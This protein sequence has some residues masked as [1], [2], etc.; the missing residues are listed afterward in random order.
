MEYLNSLLSYLS[1]SSCST[2]E[3]IKLIE[4]MK[5]RT[6]VVGCLMC[7][8]EILPPSEYYN[9]SVC[10]DG[11][12]NICPSCIQY[13]KEDTCH[14]YYKEI[15]PY[16]LNNFKAIS[17][18]TYST[19]LLNII[20]LYEERRC[21]GYRLF[22]GQVLEDYK[23][24]SYKQVGMY[25]NSIVKFLKEHSIEINSEIIICADCCPESYIIL[26][27]SLIANMICIPL[28][29]TVSKEQ[30][31][32][33]LLKCHSPL[34]FISKHLQHVF[35][36]CLS[37]FKFVFTVD[38]CYEA[39]DVNS[40]EP[41]TKTYPPLSSILF[42]DEKEETLDIDQTNIND[43]TPRLLLS[44]SGSTG[45]PKLV[46]ETE[47]MLKSQLVETK[48][49]IE[50]IT[51]SFTLI[52]QL[53]NILSKGGAIACYSGSLERLRKDILLVRPT[54]FGATPSF[55]N[56]LYSEFKIEKGS[57]SDPLSLETFKKKKVLGNRCKQV[58]ITGAKSSDYIK[59]FLFKIGLVVTDGYGTS[60]TGSLINM[61]TGKVNEGVELK[62]IDCEEMGFYVT[63]TP[64]R[65]EVVAKTQTMTT[66]YFGDDEL[67]E[68]MFTQ[69]DGV[70]YFKT[71]DVGMIED[72][73]VKIID[74]KAFCFKTQQGVFVTPTV[75][76]NALIGVLGIEQIFVFGGIEINGVMGVVYPT[77]NSPLQYNDI[78]KNIKER[79]KEKQMK[80]YETVSKV[81]IAK[82][83]FGVE[84]GLL[85]SN[86]KLNR[87]K[88]LERYKKYSFCLGFVIVEAEEETAILQQSEKGEEPAQNEKCERGA[89]SQKMENILRN[90]VKG[91]EK[92]K[93]IESV[94]EYK[95]TDFG[96]DSICMALISKS[97]QDAFGVSISVLL[98]YKMR[99]IKEIENYINTGTFLEIEENWE[100]EITKHVIPYKAIPEVNLT[101]KRT[102]LLLGA[103]G[104][105]GKFIL[106]SLCDIKERVICV[107]RGQ[108]VKRR[109]LDIFN[110]ITQFEPKEKREEITQWFEEQVTVLSGD[111][112]Q[113]NFGISKL[114]C[115][116]LQT[117]KVII[118]SCGR[119]H[120]LE[121]YDNLYPQNVIPMTTCV[122]LA[123]QN[124]AFLI[125][126]S[127]LSCLSGSGIN[128]EVKDVP[129]TSIDR[130]NGYAQSKLIA[131]KIML[132][133]EGYSKCIIRLG[134]AGF[135]RASGVANLQSKYIR[136]I[137]SILSSN[138][139]CYE[140]KS[141][142]PLEIP[143]VPI[144]YCAECV[145]KIIQ[146][147]FDKK[148]QEDSV[149]CYHL[150]CQSYTTLEETL[151]SVQ[152]ERVS[153]DE[154]KRYCCDFEKKDLG[155]CPSVKNTVAL[156]GEVP[157]YSQLEFTR[158]LTWLSK[159]E[160]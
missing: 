47:K 42:L 97:I 141:P 31:E 10:D 38:D 150:S 67:T 111:V 69:I 108:N 12:H 148:I 123:Q 86:G 131:E 62:L 109:L 101:P 102:I 13:A 94:L 98:L 50:T 9:C 68:K 41:Q 139:V 117:I 24:L 158:F 92:V 8:C 23:W 104:F 29:H 126:I 145:K 58:L 155:V 134:T 147:Y 30:F 27:A 2:S 125:Q 1:S 71:G 138:K 152:L 79:S 56:S 143:F 128:E 7:G 3:D 70:K 93:T 157:K 85:T 156:C 160:I 45:I 82:D 19:C 51:V 11:F 127:S 146:M 124:K 36:K 64:P 77:V 75:I 120:M 17:A 52:R 96:V 26:I 72:G 116:V 103:T 99:N 37:Q 88:L 112:T 115:E 4:H 55:W 122:T 110:E 20:H 137:K 95:L 118:N 140:E 106:R 107:V 113:P 90:C 83:R 87:N 43:Q 61:T 130:L 32:S 144:D 44:T 28:Q 40:K 121:S 59:E 21:I 76:E 73:R 149:T 135:D 105:V 39:Y 48:G 129:M 133:N 159:Q 60:E 14:K 15:L 16:A 78:L 142:L 46:I 66:G 18:P 74:R 34:L 53:G 114:Y 35:S 119:T 84:N 57:L 136:L 6:S 153:P 80:I 22:C 63:D 132:K 100:N 154:M 65:G 91:I 49:N 54:F 5:N 151:K 33:V 89:V 81:I 25:V